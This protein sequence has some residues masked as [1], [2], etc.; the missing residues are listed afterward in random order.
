MVLYD[1]SGRRQIHC[2]LKD[3][4]EAS[5]DFSEEQVADA[6]IVVACNINFN[7]GKKLL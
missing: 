3:I 5:Y 4:Q 6:D 7:R 2:D 1:Q